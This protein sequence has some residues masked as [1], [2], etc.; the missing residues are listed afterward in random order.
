MNVAVKAALIA[1][2]SAGIVLGQ[3]CMTVYIRQFPFPFDVRK[4]VS[5]SCTSWSFFAIFVAYGLAF[6]TNII[7]LRFFPLA[8]VMLSILAITVPAG[9]GISYILGQ[10]LTR[11]QVMGAVFILAGFLLLHIKS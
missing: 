2:A 4:A 10:P 9:I 8:Q 7:L 3:A 11:V 1:V 5:Y 6:V